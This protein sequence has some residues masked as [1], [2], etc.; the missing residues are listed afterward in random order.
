MAAHK[1]TRKRGGEQHARITCSSSRH[2]LGAIT[3]G[4]ITPLER[5]TAVWNAVKAKRMDVFGASMAPNFVGMCAFGRHDRRDELRVVRNQ[6][7][8]SFALANFRVVMIGSTDMLMTYTADVKGSEDGEEFSVQYWNPS[9]W[10][11][12]G[13]KWLTVYHG[14]AKA[15]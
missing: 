3:C 9:L 13:G 4:P 12:S 2:R 15:K 5:E 7:L 6:T 8:R 10:H 14:E 11:F 1:L